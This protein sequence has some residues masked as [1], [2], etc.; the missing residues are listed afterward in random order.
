MTRIVRPARLGSVPLGSAFRDGNHRERDNST[1][2]G[3]AG[4]LSV[5]GGDGRTRDP[6][7]RSTAPE[8]ISMYECSAQ[9]VRQPTGSVN[10]DA[11]E[12]WE[13]RFRVDR[14]G[15]GG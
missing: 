15:A 11:T 13:K 14:S 1:G 4:R 10:R 3:A 9:S 6:A 2:G 8:V 12:S 5:D 7:G